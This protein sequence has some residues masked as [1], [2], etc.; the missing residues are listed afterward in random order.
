[1]NHPSTPPTK[2][3]KPAFAIVAAIILIL[4]AGVGIAA[5]MGWLPSSSQA[6]RPGQLMT[7]PA[8]PLATATINSPTGVTQSSQYQAGAGTVTSQ[9]TA[10]AS[11]GGT[12]GGSAVAQAPVLPIAEPRVPAPAR[13]EALQEQRV[14]ERDDAVDTANKE[15]AKPVC[16]NCGVVETV[17]GQSM[18]R[19]G[20]GNDNANGSPTSPGAAV[21]NRV[22]ERPKGSKRYDVVVRMHDGQLRTVH[23]DQTVWRAGD[24]VKIE[25]GKLFVR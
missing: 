18:Q 25:D 17:N 6:G 1:M 10:G 13:K 7:P 9:S 22:E 4:F 24:Q 19:R 15:A 2:Q 5:L 20:T 8:E 23:T 14:R 21:S 11:G 12:S 3:N 16:T